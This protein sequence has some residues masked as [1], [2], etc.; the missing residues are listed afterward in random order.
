MV[1]KVGQDIYVPAELYISHGQDD[2]QGGLAEV[3]SVVSKTYGNRKKVHGIKVKEVPNKTYFW[4]NYLAENQE[5]WAKRFGMQRAKPD[6]DELSEFNSGARVTKNDIRRWLQEGK[7]KGAT[8][9]IVMSDTYDYVYYPVHVMPGNN[10][11]EVGKKESGNDIS[12]KEVY[13]LS[14][15]IEV[16]LAEQVAIHYE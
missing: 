11:R 4:E 13:S 5:K 2:I 9:V 12:V 7:E 8:H 15:D 10:P 16:Q 3:I 14:L 1:P 6:P